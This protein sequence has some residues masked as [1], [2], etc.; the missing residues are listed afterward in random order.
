MFMNDLILEVENTRLAMYVDDSTVCT[1][2]ES[3]ESI[4]NTLTSQSKPI[5][6]WINVNRMV[7][8]VDKTECMLLGTCQ[9]LRD[10]L[11]N[12]SVGED[13][14]IVTPILSHKLLGILVDCR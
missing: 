2:D 9:K 6:H 12:V 10:A 11:K 1:A 13:E 4:T 8:N 14:Y 7:L 3:V 5:Y